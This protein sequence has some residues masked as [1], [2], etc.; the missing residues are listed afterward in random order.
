MPF[1]YG[2]EAAVESPGPGSSG[3]PIAFCMVDREAEMGVL[4][5]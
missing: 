4:W 3:R 1:N 2:V 5:R